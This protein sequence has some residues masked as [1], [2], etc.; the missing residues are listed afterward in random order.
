MF[1]SELLFG[2]F[3]VS[4]CYGDFMFGERKEDKFILFLEMLRRD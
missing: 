4:D 3:F 1:F 2:L